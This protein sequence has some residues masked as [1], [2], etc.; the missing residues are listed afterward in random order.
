[1]LVNNVYFCGEKRTA[2][3]FREVR[4]IR[5]G[6]EQRTELLPGG[7]RL[8]V[9]EVTGRKLRTTYCGTW[10]LLHVVEF[11]VKLV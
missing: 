5:L 9:R 8:D 10:V 4:Q 1:V 6:G 7:L 2:F 11:L 3:Q